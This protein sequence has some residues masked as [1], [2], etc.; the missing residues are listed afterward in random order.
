MSDEA[1]LT[2]APRVKVRVTRSSSRDGGVGW[3][4]DVTDA[5]DWALIGEAIRMA[6]EAHRKLKAELEVRDAG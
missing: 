2:P 4:V 3:T 1:E 6:V 5:A